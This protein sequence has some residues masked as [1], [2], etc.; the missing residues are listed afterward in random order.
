MPHPRC[1]RSLEVALLV[2]AFPSRAFRSEPFWVGEKGHPA[3]LGWAADEALALYA[4]RKI[5]SRIGWSFGSSMRWGATRS[6]R[7]RWS[8]GEG[9]QNGR[10]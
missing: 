1:G 8:A 10:L 5:R 2:V 4:E 6:L 3:R 7:P 9:C